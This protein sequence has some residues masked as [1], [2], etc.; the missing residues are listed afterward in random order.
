MKRILFPLL[1][2]LAACQ[3]DPK[4]SDSQVPDDTPVSTGVEIFG[5]SA[6]ESIDIAENAAAVKVPV[7]LDPS[8]ASL[9][10]DVSLACQP[11]GIVEYRVEADGIL[12]TPRKQGTAVF[13][14]SAKK[15]PASKATLTVHVL[16][17]EPALVSI[18]IQKEGDSFSG[19]KLILTETGT[20]ALSAKILNEKGNS[21]MDRQVWTLKSGTDVVSLSESGVLTALT[22]GEAVVS[23]SPASA[24]ELK[25]EL[26]VSVA[27]IATVSFTAQGG[28]FNSGVL[29]LSEGGSVQLIAIVRNSL[30]GAFST[31]VTWRVSEGNCVSVDQN[32]IVKATASSGTASVQATVTARPAVSGTA[33]IRIVPNPRSIELYGNPDI[34][35]PEEI[36]K[37]GTMT[38]KVRVLPA[39]AVQDVKVAIEAQAG[40]DN[41]CKLTASQNVSGGYTNI[42]LSASNV[43]DI[44]YRDVVITSVASPSVSLRWRFYV[45]DYYDSDLKVGDYVYYNSSDKKFVSRDCGRRTDTGF[46]SDSYEMGTTPKT[47]PAVSGY[48]YIG[49]VATTDIPDEEDFLKASMLADCADPVLK[50]VS[51]FR[52][53]SLIGLDNNK[54]AHVLVVAARRAETSS[55]QIV[56]GDGTPVVSDT[57]INVYPLYPL[58]G[59]LSLSQYETSG[60]GKTYVSYGFLAYR[61]LKRYNGLQNNDGK[62]VRPVMSVASYTPSIEPASSGK[63]ST[64][65]FLPGRGDVSLVEEAAVIALGNSQS[66]PMTIGEKYWMV[67]EDSGSFAE[68]F[69][70]QKTFWDWWSER[71]NTSARVRAFLYL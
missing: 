18:T 13:T 62:R 55:W 43:S 31:P 11:E 46:L 2:C 5:I 44:K 61:L 15:G 8:T 16:E 56:F 42:T 68:A 36:K 59:V 51:G 14:L 10:E 32:G 29:P 6:P 65:W 7:A 34:S 24:P 67:E 27:A 41:A 39:D 66:D 23:V 52:R 37:G 60:Y 48:T 38:L 50:N 63:T 19:G 70:R 53:S 58:R 26:S 64:G 25:D 22:P 17:K 45:C 54:G 57:E 40:C 1:L 47:P 30:G 33:R 71:K 9:K 4:P 12:I 21:S 3:G 49:V 35:I 20:F 28:S 69:S